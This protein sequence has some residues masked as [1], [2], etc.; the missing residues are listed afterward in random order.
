MERSTVS[1]NSGDTAV[2]P[3]FGG[4][5]YMDGVSTI[6]DS[7]ITGNS[8]QGNVAH[9]SGMFIG[10]GASLTLDN[11]DV[12][13]NKVVIGGEETVGD[14]YNCEGIA[15]ADGNCVAPQQGDANRDAKVDMED[16]LALSA[17]FGQEGDWLNG[18]FDLDGT[19]GFED[20]LILAANYGDSN[21]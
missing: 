7:S 17:A 16:F 15:T 6:S 5:I 18:D 19:V 4:G 2:A 13:G 3:I 14:D 10:I 21:G 20:F 11:V 8:V 1:G 12:N 9:G